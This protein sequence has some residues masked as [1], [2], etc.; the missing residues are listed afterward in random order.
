MSL[1]RA[2]EW[3]L[4]RREKKPDRVRDTHRE[5]E[6]RTRVRPQNKKTL[7]ETENSQEGRPTKGG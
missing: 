3:E 4:E 1:H 2:N 5:M 6:E 7:N